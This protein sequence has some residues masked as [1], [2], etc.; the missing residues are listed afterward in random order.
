[1]TR[2]PDEIKK[3]LAYCVEPYCPGEKC[4]YWNAESCAQDKTYDALAY[5]RQLE[6]TVSEKEKVVAELLKKVEQLQADRD[7]LQRGMIAATEI[8][9]ELQ[10]ERDAA[11]ACVPKT[12]KYCKHD[13]TLNA[14]GESECE[15]DSVFPSGCL[16]GNTRWEWRGVQKEAPSC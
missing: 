15:L 3:G 12:C 13:G 14:W 7:A 16:N 8:L 2:T 11:V 9:N 4:P 10:A 6:A 5:I 1:M